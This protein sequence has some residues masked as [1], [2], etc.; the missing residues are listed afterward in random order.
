LYRTLEACWQGFVHI[1]KRYVPLLGN[2]A[3]LCRTL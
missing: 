2:D 1:P 3:H